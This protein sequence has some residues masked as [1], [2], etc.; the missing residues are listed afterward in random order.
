MKL[1]DRMRDRPGADVAI[2]PMR[3]RHVGGALAIERVVYPRP[4][5]ERVFHSELDQVRDGARVYL[6]ARRGRNVVGYAGLMFVVDE[7]HVTNVAV[8]PERPTHHRL[9]HER[10]PEQVGQGQQSLGTGL[11]DLDGRGHRQARSRIPSTSSAVGR[12]G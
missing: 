2:E 7:A 8:H 5:S 4:W 3:H 6:V 9:D 11:A 12:D 10:A 1:L